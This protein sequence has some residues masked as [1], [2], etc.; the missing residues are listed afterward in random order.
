MR[1]NDK[2][3]EFMEK[4]ISVVSYSQQIWPLKLQKYKQ[5]NTEEHY[6]KAIPLQEKTEAKLKK[7]YNCLRKLFTD[8]K[9]QN[10]FTQ[11]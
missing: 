1:E 4:G 10:N 11:K 9:T 8:L 2:D 6:A 5:A 3:N 7:I